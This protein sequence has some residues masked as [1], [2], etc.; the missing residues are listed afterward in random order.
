MHNSRTIQMQ[1]DQLMNQQIAAPQQ[2]QD[3]RFTSF[4][5]S[6]ASTIADRNVSM[7]EVRP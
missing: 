3:N 1:N 2:G 7:A 5:Q 4:R 6:S